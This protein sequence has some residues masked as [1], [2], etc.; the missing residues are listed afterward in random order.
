MQRSSERRASPAASSLDMT[1]RHTPVR[2]VNDDTR[3]RAVDQDA[4]RAKRCA[5]SSAFRC[6][7]SP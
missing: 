2:A 1:E 6:G 4:W 3:P 5:V 7:R